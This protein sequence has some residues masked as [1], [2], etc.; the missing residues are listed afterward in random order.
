VLNFESS[1]MR[2]LTVAFSIFI[3]SMT[4]MSSAAPLSSEESEGR[5]LS[6]EFHCLSASEIRSTLTPADLYRALPACV[7][8]GNFEQASFLYGLAGVY[9]RFDSLRV[10]DAS[11]HQILPVLKN[12]AF[13]AISAKQKSAFQAYAGAL[14]DDAN[15]REEL[16]RKVAQVGPPQYFPKY[17]ILHGLNAVTGSVPDDGVIIRTFNPQLAWKQSLSEYLTCR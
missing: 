10:S 16:C 17:M 5:A 12:A 6:D 8:I 7:E 13:A 2:F 11:A 15:R 4:V 9:G 14:F 3:T 1:F